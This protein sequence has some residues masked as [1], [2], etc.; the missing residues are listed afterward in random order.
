MSQ[1][2]GSLFVS[3][4]ADLS[5]LQRGLSSAATQVQSSGLA[6]Q[7]ALGGVGQVAGGFLAANV[8]MGA[9]GAITDAFGSTIDSAKDFERT[10]SGI[11]AVS[12]AN[13]NEMQSLSALTLKLGADTTFTANEAGKGIEE[14]IKGGVSL[15]DIASGAAKSM[16][17][18]AA[19]GDVGLADSAEIA[20]NSLAM[21]G[22]E[23]EDMAHVANQIAGAA[24][25][26]S[27]S[28]NDFRYSLAMSGA[29]A[30]ASGQSFDDLAQG[31][32]IMGKSGLKG[33]DAGTSLK[34]MLMNLQP[35]T[36]KQYEAMTELGLVTEDG[37]NKFI[38]ANGSFKS[39]AEIAELLKTSTMG[40]TESERLMA[41]ETIFGS[42]AIRAAAILAKEGQAGFNDMA[43]AMGNVT[44]ESVAME[45]TSNLEGSMERWNG[46]METVK[47]TLGTALIPA[48]TTLLEK[49]TPLIQAFAEWLPGALT[50]AGD[51][52]GI[53]GD[54]IAFTWDNISDYVGL[55]AALFRGDWATVWEN[56]QK[57][58]TRVWDAIGGT[59]KAG[60]NAMITAIN[61]LIRGIN[62]IGINAGPWTVGP[63]GFQVTIPGVSI[64]LPDI[65]YIPYLG[66]GGV[67]TRSTLAMIG[68]RGPEAVVPL[69]DGSIINYERLADA[70]AKRLG[71]QGTVIE[72]DGR[73]V[74]QAI[75][76]YLSGYTGIV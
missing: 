23:G 69:R 43:G 25:A 62:A 61:G 49:L 44:A 46:A 52:L 35:T 13:A 47:I 42:D 68:E 20:A 48:L 66:T 17:D 55:V 41:L 75:R 3:V 59:V 30:S 12:G 34:T 45:K 71:G 51:F 2:I 4:G 18:L 29:V 14:L 22:L 6:M 63:P 57:I 40:L 28:V 33:S 72:L 8:V 58:V 19:A 73:R 70:I 10:M 5:G 56:A 27:L 74:G 24:N 1:E 32:A 50:V 39:M 38:N 37:A 7:R 67:V 53:L 36:K 9:T 60:V 26:S 64:G 16:L 54:V 31:I 76:P 21:F 15:G 11:K 65:P